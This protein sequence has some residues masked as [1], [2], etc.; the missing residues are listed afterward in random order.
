MTVGCGDNNIGT[1]FGA[2]GQGSQAVGMGTAGLAGGFTTP[3]ILAGLRAGR[4]LRVA[5]IS[6]LLGL[7]VT[8]VFDLLTNVAFPL[9][10]GVPF[11]GWWPYLLAGIPFCL[12]HV[13]SN[14]L[15]FSLVLPPAHARLAR[16]MGVTDAI[17]E[18]RR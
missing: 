4:R 8:I 7:G 17:R 5:L 6:L 12:I 10:M 2:V 3:M 18:G 16:L 13:T 14:A 15:I 1:V 11:R 9:A